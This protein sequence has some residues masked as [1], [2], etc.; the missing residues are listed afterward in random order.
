MQNLSKYAVLRTVLL[1]TAMALHDNDYNVRCPTWRRQVH[2]GHLCSLREV[3]HHTRF[4]RT[5][6]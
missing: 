1:L 6:E 2:R 3:A 4:V 5:R